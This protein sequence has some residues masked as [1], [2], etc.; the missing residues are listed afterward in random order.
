M[1]TDKGQ[2]VPKGQ[3]H[4]KNYKRGSVKDF[5]WQANDQWLNRQDHNS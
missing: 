3:T 5:E 4:D 2:K 1:K